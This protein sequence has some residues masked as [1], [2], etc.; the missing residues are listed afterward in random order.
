MARLPLHTLSTQGQMRVRIEKHD[1]NGVVSL[2]WQVSPSQ[3]FGE[4]RHL[5]YRLDTLVI[6][7]R[8]DEAGPPTPKVIRLGSLRSICRELELT[9][10]GHNASDIKQALSQN[11]SATIKARLFYRDRVGKQRKLE[12][13]FSRYSV[14]F[15]GDTL[16]DGA[17]A[18]GVYV[19]MNDIYQGFLN[20]VPLRPLDF[21]YLRQLQPSACRFYEVV[22]FKIYAAL[23]H[24]WPRVSITYS[25]YCEATGQRRLMTGTEVSKQMY[26]LHKPHLVN[27][28]L[29]KVEFEKTL[30]VGG[31]LDWNIWYVPGP[32]A[33]DEYLKFSLGRKTSDA[34]VETNNH[35]L[36]RGQSPAEELVTHFLTI[37]F[38]RVKRRIASKEVKMAEKML[39]LHNVEESKSILSEALS[40]AIESGTKP[41]WMTELKRCIEEKHGG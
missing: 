41:L 16:P 32:R 29:A 10:S 26:K 12:A 1:D 25:E 34:A 20:H 33:K 24:G 17:E 39:E 4:P 40:A 9:E 14:V 7:K 36:P 3:Q 22:S 31:Q 38:G 35:L 5:A 11:A 8:I 28:Y 2:L 19:V 13:V 37:R 30:D 21:N 6:N 23:K 18:D 15:T 27:G